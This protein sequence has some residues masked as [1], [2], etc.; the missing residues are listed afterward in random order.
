MSNLAFS[1]QDE[2]ADAIDALHA[3]TALYT[4][5]PIVDGLL[6]RL[7]WPDR[8]HTLL[9]PSAGDG[10]FLI[11]ALDR[12]EPPPGDRDTAM[13]LRGVE[14][15]PGAVI[16]ARSAIADRLRAFGWPPSDASD[17]AHKI[18]IE[19]DF[20]ECRDLGTFDLIAGNPPYL[21]LAHLPDF[22]KELYAR[23]TPAFAQADIQHAFLAKCL[24]CLTPEGELAMV[25]SD[26]ILFNQ[27]ASALRAHL[28]T[29]LSLD[30]VQRLDAATAFY[31]PKMRRKGT[32][33]RCHPVEVVLT[34][35]PNGVALTH[36][37]IS[38]D[39]PH[40]QH[41]QA[42]C[43]LADIATVRLAP[44]LGPR[45][46]FNIDAAIAST[47]PPEC[48]IPIVEND[49]VGADDTLGAPRRYAIRTDKNQ[50][51]PAATAAH[52]E[53]ALP[54]M[55]QRG[56]RKTWWMPPETI[57]L[58][59]S[60]P[61][62]LIPRIAKRLRAIP[63]PAGILPVDHNLHIASSDTISQEDLIE[64]V[65]CDEAQAFARMHAPRLENG[66]LDLRASL[67]RRIPVHR[68]PS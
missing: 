13:R 52:L 55:P 68:R 42:D 3:A 47:L 17:I 66:Y 16:S 39:D 24:D 15:H 40:A 61:G 58:D 37:P 48:L 30:H 53:A 28:G 11:A 46:I 7:G 65:T 49:N 22:F 33:P 4:V 18:I 54:R 26:R 59:L 10:S 2:R 1:F 23:I 12:L 25:V 38:P 43:T 20:L 60:R 19:G 8:A 27:G 32:P 14:L 45:G 62:I 63:I 51:P 36:A 21:R 29:R 31:R 57:T 64:L 6:D 35:S 9:D 34:P 50:P 5:R 41:E 56:R 44:W 67:L